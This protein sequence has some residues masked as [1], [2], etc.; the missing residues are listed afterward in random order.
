[1]VMPKLIERYR[2]HRDPLLQAADGIRAAI[3]SGSIDTARIAGLVDTLQTAI[4]PFDERRI[5]NGP[6]QVHPVGCGCRL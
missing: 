3:G 6:W 5:G 1:M 4:V 2:P